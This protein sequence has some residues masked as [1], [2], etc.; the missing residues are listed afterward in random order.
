MVDLAGSER[1]SKTGATGNTL[2]E[3][4]KINQSLSELGNCINAL[5]DSKSRHI[6]FRNSLLTHF[7]K[8]ALGGNSKTTLICTASKMMVHLDES[9][10]TLSFA[11][12]AKKIQ[13]KAAANVMKS[14]EEMMRMIE[15]LKTEVFA[16]RAHLEVHDCKH[17]ITSS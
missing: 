6:P 7:L 11:Q 9:I 2:K 17:K 15:R 8:D 5:T 3:A 16:L 14:P 1:Q 13:T 4:T 10:Q 12:R